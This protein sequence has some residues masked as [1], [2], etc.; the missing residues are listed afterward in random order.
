[1]PMT[2]PR[3]M[4]LRCRILI[5]IAYIDQFILINFFL[6]FFLIPL[7]VFHVSLI[8]FYNLS[9]SPCVSFKAQAF[10]LLRSILPDI[11]TLQ[12]LGLIQG[13]WGVSNFF[14]FF[15]LLQ[16]LMLSEV[17]KSTFFQKRKNIDP[18]PLSWYHPAHIFNLVG[19]TCSRYCI[20]Y[21][22]CYMHRR[23]FWN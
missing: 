10:F 17:S 20:S 16:Q 23:P 19:W 4:N 2:L 1:M 15:F 8:L 6:L 12:V 21:L 13:G 9:P 22:K 3:W 14:S 11:K 5:N 7:S 18:W